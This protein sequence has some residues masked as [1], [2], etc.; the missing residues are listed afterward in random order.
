MTRDFV[1]RHN[2]V[3]SV[4]LQQTINGAEL[5]G[6]EVRANFTRTGELINVSSTLLPAASKDREL[7][8]TAKA[9]LSAEH[10]VHTAAVHLGITAREALGI[11]EAFEAKPIAQRVGI[12]ET[13][14]VR[15][16]TVGRRANEE[17]T[18]RAASAAP[19]ASLCAGHV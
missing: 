16:E 2:G 11:Q 18:S 10:A 19:A 1:T 15:N 17:P 4:T 13:Q 3:R 7:A 5:I 6:A 12:G 9:H 14:T 8:F